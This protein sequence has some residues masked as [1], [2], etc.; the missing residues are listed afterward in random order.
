MKKFLSILLSALCA[1]LPALALAQDST[2]IT[3]T[4]PASHTI[5]VICGEHGKAVINGVSYTGTFTVQADRLGTLAIYAQPDGDYAV[6]AI[7]V[8]DMDGVTIQG[9]WVTLAGVHGENTVTITFCYSPSAQEAGPWSIVYDENGQ[10]QDFELLYM[11]TADAPAD[12][13][14]R[15]YADAQ[16]NAACRRLM[17]DGTQ[18]AALAQAM[19]GGML[20][21]ENGEAIIALSAAEA[22]KAVQGEAVL[23]VRVAPEAQ[24]YAVS[25][26]LHAGERTTALDLSMQV[27]LPAQAGESVTL[28][29]ARHETALRMLAVVGEQATS[30]TMVQ[31]VPVQPYRQQL[32]ALPYTGA[33]VYT[34]Q[35]D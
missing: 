30:V 8:A 20:M 7:T 18:L 10:L 33:G 35:N 5:T 23:E 27:C 29:D 32:L 22:A 11:H 16:G 21:F 24:G 3:T 19:D 4:V 34:A 12:V 1:L 15:A 31:D 9:R 28:P 13:L 17:L 14:V 6:D 26:C 2:T 25:A